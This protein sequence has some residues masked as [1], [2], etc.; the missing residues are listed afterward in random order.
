MAEINT[1]VTV[2]PIAVVTF[3]N[4]GC[5]LTKDSP[6]SK[7]SASRTQVT[8]CTG[9]GSLRPISSRSASI[10]SSVKLNAANDRRAY[11]SAGS[12][13]DRR[14]SRKEI[15]VTTTS[16]ISISRTLLTIN[17]LVALLIRFPPK[18]I[19]FAVRQC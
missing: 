17:R 19:S 8:Y 5:P 15:S 13:G 4:T 11:A 6:K 1:I 18:K 12:M 9:S 2:M 7:W 16:V 3:S 14:T 10:C